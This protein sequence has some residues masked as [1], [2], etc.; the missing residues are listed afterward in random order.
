MQRGLNL[1]I[2]ADYRRKAVT[3]AEYVSFSPLAFWRDLIVDAI[4]LS[5]LWPPVLF[6]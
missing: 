1:S 2:A 6:H 5:F 4:C 3:R